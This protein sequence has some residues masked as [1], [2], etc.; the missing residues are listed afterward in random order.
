MY[1]MNGKLSHSSNVVVIDMWEVM[2][3]NYLVLCLEDSK[4]AVDI[5]YIDL[6]LMRWV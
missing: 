5:K 2:N 3:S 1:M 6:H 4:V